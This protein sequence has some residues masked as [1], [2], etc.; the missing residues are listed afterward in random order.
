MITRFFFLF[1]RLIPGDWSFICK[2]ICLSWD[3]TGVILRLSICYLRKSYLI[4]QLFNVVL[5]KSADISCLSSVP[6]LSVFQCHNGL[7][8]HGLV[9]RHIARDVDDILCSHYLRYSHLQLHLA[10]FGKAML[11]L[12]FKFCICL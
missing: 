9:P 8:K 10:F 11:R 6:G 2:L 12:T 7:S 4:K 5:K 1:R 3:Y